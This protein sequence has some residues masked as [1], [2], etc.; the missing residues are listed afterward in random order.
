M[1]GY[2]PTLLFRKMPFH[3]H[4]YARNVHL[5]FFNDTLLILS[6]YNNYYCSWSLNFVVFLT[7]VE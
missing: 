6:L 2:I 5:N 4:I 3:K 7:V 1:C